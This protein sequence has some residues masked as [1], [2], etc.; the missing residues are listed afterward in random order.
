MKKLFVPLVALVAVGAMAFTHF[1]IEP[2]AIGSSLPEGNSKLTDIS[3]KEITLAASKKKNGLL[4]IFS[5][6]TCP[7]VVKNQARNN[8]M[9]AYAE[10][11]NI[12]VVII[13]SNEAQRS[14]ADSYDAMKKYAT[15]Q[16]YKWS[17]AV[18]KN[19]TLA[20]A[21]GATKTPE[22]FLFNKDSKLVYHG[23][24][25]DSPSKPEEA[26]RKHLQLAID[27]AV[28]G[29]DVTVKTSKSVGCTIKRVK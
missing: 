26:T 12:G 16:G 6:N 18:D 4:V 1:A 14:D 20:N 15:D 28:A 11:N 29:K 21:F 24:F 17:Y 10:K 9:C 2:L 25:D 7:Y 23:A 5:C 13:N 22:I 19:S 8:E 3:G 27:E